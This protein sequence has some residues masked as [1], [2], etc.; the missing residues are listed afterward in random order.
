MFR[1]R[2]KHGAFVPH[3]VADAFAGQF[4]FGHAGALSAAFAGE[5][6]AFQHAVDGAGAFTAARNGG[7]HGG[8]A[9]S[10]VARGEN[11]P[12][13]RGEG[14]VVHDD[15][16]ALHRYLARKAAQFRSLADGENDVGGGKMQR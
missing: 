16:V 4:V 9:G 6:R 10:R 8:R 15:A 7:H 13:R 3:F 12:C 14:D 5:V 2:G 11:A 1:I